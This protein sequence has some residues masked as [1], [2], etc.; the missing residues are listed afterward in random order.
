MRE[1]PWW[2]DLWQGMQAG[3]K[4]SKAEDYEQI[5]H[6]AVAAGSA[7]AFSE[8]LAPREVIQALLERS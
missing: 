2:Q 5:L 7:T 1:I 3:D 8:G 4:V 6:L